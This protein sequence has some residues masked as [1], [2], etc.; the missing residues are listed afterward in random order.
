VTVSAILLDIEGT[1]AP[2][3]F[4]AEVLFPF[5][6]A[7]LPEFVRGHADHPQVIEALAETAGLEGRDL[8][9][10]EAIEVL[11]GWI[12]ADRKATPLKSLQGM[13][14]REGYESGE[15]V[16]PLYPDAAEAMRAW[17]AQG[18]RLD[19]YS[20]GSVEAQILL[21]RHSDAG[22][23]TPLISGYFDTRTG[24]KQDAA[25]YAAIA[26]AIGHEPASIVF[27]SDA[28]AE[29][30]A[31]RK[32]GMTSWRIDRT[33]KPGTSVA[34]PDGTQ[35]VADPDGTQAA[36]DFTVVAGWISAG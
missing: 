19:I 18:L 21:Y 35:A 15:I 16:S 36:A 1:T 4:V 14:W 24:A 32:A 11:L 8:S 3:T 9:S 20:S 33:L 10:D 34:D 7:R 13:I 30:A 27:L 29:V 22:D 23:L 2:I 31:A 17:H 6:A 25:S 26:K 12:R 28:P 5:A